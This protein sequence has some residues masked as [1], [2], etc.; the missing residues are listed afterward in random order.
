M[1]ITLGLVIF[2]SWTITFMIIML[3]IVIVAWKQIKLK[4]L[5]IFGKKRDRG[6]VIEIKNN[7][8]IREHFVKFTKDTLEIGERIY[9]IKPEHI[10]MSDDWGCKAL[11]VSEAL[12][13]SIKPEDSSKWAGLDSDTITKLIKRAKNVGSQEALEFIQ[14]ITRL[15]P[16]VLAGILIVSAI[17][18]FLLIQIWMATKGGV[19]GIL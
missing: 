1:N 9:N 7:R 2:V 5:A 14:K 18:I 11:V 13:S 10:F 12:K 3:A 8:S 15:A 17:Q 19:Q 6:L 4:W 16:L